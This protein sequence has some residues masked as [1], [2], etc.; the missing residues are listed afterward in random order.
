M[1]PCDATRHSR[2][3]RRRRSRDYRR[4]RSRDYRHRRSRDYRRRRSRESG[5]P[6]T[7]APLALLRRPG[8]GRGL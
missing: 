4:R 8:E 3:C 6:V 1:S 5:N 2:D 7:L